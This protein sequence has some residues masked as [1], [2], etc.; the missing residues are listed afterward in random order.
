MDPDPVALLLPLQPVPV[1]EVVVLAAHR[2][3]GAAGSS[4]T[5]MLCRMNDVEV[6]TLD[7]IDVILLLR[8]N[9]V[10][11]SLHGCNLHIVGL[12]GYVIIALPETL[13]LPNAC[14]I[15]QDTISKQSHF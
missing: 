7:V 9:L 2:R 12:V 4:C 15:L 13:H 11:C 3:R 1:V 10:C 8:S 5:E 6:S 14:L